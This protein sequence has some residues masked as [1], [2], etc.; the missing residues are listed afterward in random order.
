MGFGSLVLAVGSAV[1]SGSV[2]SSGEATGAASFAVVPQA[3]TVD[4]TKAAAS[5]ART[6]PKITI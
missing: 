3:A 4:T 2:G 6:R 5:T 1:V